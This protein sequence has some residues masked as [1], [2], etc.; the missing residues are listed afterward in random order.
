MLLGKLLHV[1]FVLFQKRALVKSVE[2]MFL[3]NR[4]FCLPL[5]QMHSSADKPFQPLVSLALSLLMLWI[6][7]RSSPQ[8]MILYLRTKWS[9]S[10]ERTASTLLWLI[11]S[12][13][14]WEACVFLRLMRRFEL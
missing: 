7:Y 5:N 12:R 13:K 3:C 11:A 14:L 9:L 2:R 1:A 10:P 4:H 8:R 6:L